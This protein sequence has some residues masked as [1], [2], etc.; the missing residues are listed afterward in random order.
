M[1]VWNK[2]G[3]ERFSD[4][5]ETT[6]WQVF[7]DSCD[8]VNELCEHVS[9]YINFCENNCFEEKTIKIFGNNKPWVT[10]DMKTLLIEKKRFFNVKNKEQ[11][12][13]THNKIKNKTRRSR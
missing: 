7:I 12:K 9:E 3:T 13:N 10:K 1:R 2:C 5:M 6:D 4:C 8:N 11:C